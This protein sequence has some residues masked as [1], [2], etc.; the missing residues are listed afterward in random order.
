MAPTTLG[1][2]LYFLSKMEQFRGNK[3]KAVEWLE[4]CKTETPQMYSYLMA[5]D[6]AYDLE[7]IRQDLLKKTTR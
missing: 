7:L 2:N 4:R 1:F 5:Q 3:Q 6:P